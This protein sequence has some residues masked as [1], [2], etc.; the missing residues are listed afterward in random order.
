V[1]DTKEPRQGKLLKKIFKK[2]RKN[3]I[4]PKRFFPNNGKKVVHYLKLWESPKNI[5]PAAVLY[6]A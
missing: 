3:I 5:F 1:E 4:F 6:Q 2:F